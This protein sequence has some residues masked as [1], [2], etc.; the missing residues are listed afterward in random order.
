MTKLQSLKTRLDQLPETRRLKALL[1]N[2]RQFHGRL[3]ETE[4]QFDAA[5]RQE[6]HANAVFGAKSVTGV[7][8]ARRKAA[9]IAKQLGT[10]LREDIASVSNPR[11]RVNDSVTSIGEI[12][13]GAVRDVKADWQ[14]L[15]DQK[16][17]PY[18]KLVEVARKLSLDGAEELATVMQHL[19]TARESIPGTAERAS[20]V[21][22][23]LQQLPSAVQKLGLDDTAVRQFLIDAAGGA[24][25]L[26]A[27]ADNPS[28]AD[29]IKR[30]KLWDLFRV[31]TS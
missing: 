24:A 10:K 23:Y 8:A 11:A 6:E 5:A 14:R 7:A 28:I 4:R 25:K 29:F 1:E 3:T 15:I 12:A 16:I 18:D 31:S 20:T 17:K 26:K 9:R 21:A 19:R 30:Y 2:M 22:G 13:A 27:F